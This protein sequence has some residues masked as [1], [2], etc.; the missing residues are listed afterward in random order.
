M[1]RFATAAAVVAVAV[2]GGAAKYAWDWWKVREMQQVIADHLRDP[3]S[4]RY[5]DI[6]RVGNAICGVV[7]AKNGMGGYVGY[8]RFVLAESGQFYSEPETEENSG[9][10]ER[11]LED[12]RARID[13]LTIYEAQC[14]PKGRATAVGDAAASR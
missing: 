7:N 3:E 14:Q 4:A 9:S 5:R 11:R 10:S 6:F 8:R 1:K 2:A 13:F 12:L